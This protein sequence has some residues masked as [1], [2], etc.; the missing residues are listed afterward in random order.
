MIRE[1]RAFSTACG[2]WKLDISSSGVPPKVIHGLKI[3]FR[4]Q[5][6]CDFQPVSVVLLFLLV[7]RNYQLNESETRRMMTLQSELRIN[8]LP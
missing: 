3:S 5:I 4:Q 1:L 7:N 8:Y 2:M 6:K